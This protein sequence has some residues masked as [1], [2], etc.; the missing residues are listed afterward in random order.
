MNRRD[1]F[2]AMAGGLVAVATTELWT[3]SR[4]IF[5]PPRG[6]WP[7]HEVSGENYARA[8]RHFYASGLRSLGLQVGDLLEVVGYSDKPE[9]FRVQRVEHGIER[10]AIEFTSID[11]PIVEGRRVGSVVL[12]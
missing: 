2:K 3:P 4:S 1:L 7:L 9:L 8:A 10:D 12:S 11:E 5:L 6:G